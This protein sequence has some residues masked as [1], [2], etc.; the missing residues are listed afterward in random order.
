MNRMFTDPVLT[1]AYPDLTA[2]GGPDLAPY[3]H[4]LDM[5]VIASPIDFL[6]VNHYHQVIVSHDPRD[7]HL[8]AAQRAAEPASTSFGWSVRPESIHHVLV[9]AGGYTD[10][11]LY[12]TESGACFDDYVDPTGQVRDTARIDYLHGYLEA[13]ADAIA[14]GL[15]V[16]GYYA[17]SL[18]DNFEWAEG[19]SKRFGLVFVDY[20]T[21][22]RIPKA[23]A[24]WYREQIAAH[25]RTVGQDRPGLGT[26]GNTHHPKEM[27][28]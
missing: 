2:L 23:S 11:P 27:A 28:R 25:T 12:V 13:V 7:L 20:A 18:L 10:L 16:R 4:D 26:A 22:T 21:Q 17:W 1:G 24:G 6:G 8:G 9:R 15:D 14:D 5:S 3:V 19:Y